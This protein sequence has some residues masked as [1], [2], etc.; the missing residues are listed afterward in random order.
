MYVL[1][2]FVITDQDHYSH[3]IYL[4]LCQLDLSKF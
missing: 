3:D 1:Q 4:H 2:A